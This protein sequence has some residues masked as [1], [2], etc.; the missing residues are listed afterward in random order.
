MK[1]IWIKSLTIDDKGNFSNEVLI[2]LSPS[3]ETKQLK[4]KPTN[5]KT[6]NDA[7]IKVSFASQKA[8]VFF[9]KNHI[10]VDDK[11]YVM[12]KRS[13]SSSRQG[14]VLF[15]R[16][17]LFEKMDDWSNCGI[18]LANP[19]SREKVSKNFLAF[20]AY[21]AL[22]LSGC[23]N[24]VHLNPKNILIMK[25]LHSTFM[26]DVLVVTDKEPTDEYPIHRLP[27]I[28]KNV[29]TYEG[30]EQISNCIWDGQGLLDD[31]IFKENGYSDKSMMILRNRFFKSCVFRTKLQKWF[32]DNGLFGEIEKD[33]NGI[34]IHLNGYTEATRYEDIKVVVTYS[35]LKYIKF[36]N[37]PNIAIKKWMNTVKDLFG[38]V[39]TDKKTPYFDG[40]YVKTNYQLLN[41]I[42]MTEDSVASFLQLNK[43]VIEK[44]AAS[45][46]AFVAYQKSISGESN[47]IIGKE[48]I[49]NGK[50]FDRSFVNSD[51]Y[52]NPRLIVCGKL[53]ELSSKF[54][55]TSFYKAFIGD[56]VKQLYKS[57]GRGRVFV[58]GT[59]A[60][61]LG[62]PIEMLRYVVK[63]FDIPEGETGTSIMES[64][65]YSPF[66][67]VGDKILGSRSPHILPGN[68]LI[69]NNKVNYNNKIDFG[70]ELIDEYF[71]L[72]REIVCI[73]SIG[74]TI[75]DRLNGSDQDGDT[76]LL[77]NDR[78]LVECANR[79]DEEYRHVFDTAKF[80]VPVNRISML[81][82]EEKADYINQNN[83]IDMNKFAIVDHKV[84]NNNIGKIIDLSQEYNSILW[85]IFNT[86]YHNDSRMMQNLYR[87]YA[88]NC[89]LEVLSNIEIDAAKGKT[90][91]KTGGVYSLLKVEAQKISNKKKPLFFAGLKEK[92]LGF[93]LDRHPENK[94]NLAI[95]D[96]STDTNEYLW[97]SR[98]TSDIDAIALDSC[99][100][101]YKNNKRNFRR[102]V[103]TKDLSVGDEV[104][105]AFTYEKE[106]KKKPKLLGVIIKNMSDLNRF[107]DHLHQFDNIKEA[108]DYNEYSQNEVYAV[109]GTISKFGQFEYEKYET[110]M[111]YV[112]EN[113]RN[114]QT[115]KPGKGEV[116]LT[117][118]YRPGVSKI[119]KNKCDKI[120]MEFI[121]R[122][123]E[124]EK[125][126][127]IIFENKKEESEL[128]SKVGLSKESSSEEYRE[129]LRRCAIFG[130]DNFFSSKDR[131]KSL[132]RIIDKKAN[133]APRTAFYL[134]LYLMFDDE[135]P[136]D[137]YKEIFDVDFTRNVQQAKELEDILRC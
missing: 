86:K 101:K 10:S 57:I 39:K 58:K 60:T 71:V 11:K 28:G 6:V 73:N 30:R 136:H 127:Q 25:D 95:K 15:I 109:K 108:L 2:V 123:E 90:S 61:I 13:A 126:R 130:N 75:L 135:N 36:F 62:N 92:K 119:P 72:N 52:F 116:T 115:I 3:L 107:G 129:Y 89:I 5:E 78:L 113:S 96:D 83:E 124:A 85:D 21:K 56:Y 16:D 63:K 91:F 122:L 68:I 121:D 100:W 22:T 47:E 43:N 98:I 133:N 12:Y 128:L 44:I 67:D 14:N 117:D 76:I 49:G 70:A 7:F 88:L 93:D 4:L 106:T 110:T 41:T 111:D 17:D 81:S 65:I 125:V 51:S 94:G 40:N 82:N 80:T 84:A 69:A 37:D 42:S 33:D 29:Y 103:D 79:F 59:Y 26:A 18:D 66:F 46:K 8:R 137:K 112:Y 131:I 105:I 54:D 132:I 35:S 74:D 20:Q 9:Y 55:K 53:V 97:F 134:A 114:M 1:H 24:F 77:T 38:V 50:Y 102:N 120:A 87:I 27:S 32:K 48:D 45:S 104:F 64:K 99:L 118:C 34:P 23:E 31:D 19:E